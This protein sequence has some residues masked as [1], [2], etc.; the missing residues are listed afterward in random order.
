[1]S[2]GRSILAHP[3]R[4]PDRVLQAEI[5]GKLAH[6]ALSARD[7]PEAFQLF[8]QTANLSPAI[9]SASTRLRFGC[10]LEIGAAHYGVWFGKDG[11]YACQG[12]PD[13][14][15]IIFRLSPE[16]AVKLAQGSLAPMAARQGG[17]LSVEGPQ[18]DAQAFGQILALVQAQFLPRAAATQTPGEHQLRLGAVGAGALAWF[19]REHPL[20]RLAATYA[21]G[22]ESDCESLGE[23][24]ESGVG[25]VLLAGPPEQY[26][27]AAAACAAR[28]VPYMA[29]DAQRFLPAY[30]YMRK[31]VKSGLIGEVMLVRCFEGLNETAAISRPNSAGALA[32]AN[33]FGL[34][35]FVLQSECLEVTSILGRQL[36]ESQD[37]GEDTAIAAA[38]FKNGAMAE[39]SVCYAQQTAA[40]C[41]ME[42]IGSRGTILENHAWAKP[43]RFSSG[44]PRMGEDLMVWVE[45]EIEHAAFPAYRDLAVREALTYLAKCVEEG[46][47]PDN[48]PERGEACVLACYQSAIE[49]RPVAVSER[50]EAAAQEILRGLAAAVPTRGKPVGPQIV[51]LPREDWEGYELKFSYTTEHYYDLEIMECDGGLGVAFTVRAFGEPLEKRSTDTLYQSYWEGAEAFGLLEDGEL[52]ACIELWR[53]D[54]SKRC[55]VTQLLVLEEHRRK[56]YGRALMAFAEA[57]AKEHGCRALMLETQSCNEK[58]IAF[59]L[60]QGLQLY[61][62]DRSCY[63]NEDIEKREIRMELGKTV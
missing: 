46:R 59:Y 33:K 35:E 15:S 5:G 18:A 34:L 22:S 40:C 11:C 29:A 56:G 39:I 13:N 42:I 23:L 1:M 36:G 31:I 10:Q 45:P 28:G 14:P 43:V 17:L 41:E 55:R 8:A 26:R 32:A 12:D 44:D 49:G 37:G 9:R 27:Q 61:G 4:T 62:F 60:S 24:L 57:W 6:A 47:A 20:V 19:E 48:N 38:R 63:S 58:A 50:S 52:I 2:V 25:A 51:P 21:T 16:T 53:E 7:L 3:A 54:W 30:N